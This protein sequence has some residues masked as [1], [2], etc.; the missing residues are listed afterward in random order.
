MAEETPP[1][2]V[3]PEKPATTEESVVSTTVVPEEPVVEEGS[4]LLKDLVILPPRQQKN[5]ATAVEQTVIRLP[6]IRAEE[7]VQSLRAA[8][9]ELVGFAAMTNYRLELESSAPT[10]TVSA[11]EQ[12]TPIVSPFTG[13]GAVVAVPVQVKSLE[14]D[15]SADTAVAAET[16][17]RTVTVLDDFGDLTALDPALLKDGSAFGIVLERYDASAVKDHVAR[18]RGLLDGSAPVVYSLMEQEAAP[19][20]VPAETAEDAVT[21]KEAAK[22]KAKKKLPALPIPN[23]PNGVKTDGSNLK[24]F[25]YMACG[26]DPELYHGSKRVTNGSEGGIKEPKKKKKGK[27]NKEEEKAAQEDDVKVPPEQLVREKLPRLNELEETLRIPCTI[28]Y[29]GFHPPPATR[30]CLGDIAYLEITPPDTT[31]PVVFV[32]A[33]GTGFYV[34]KSS[35]ARGRAV[36]DPSPAVEPCF[37]HTLLDCLLQKSPSIRDAWVAALAASKER[38]E[39]LSVVNDGPFTSLFRVAIRGDFGGFQS[40]ATAALAQLQLD[41]SLNTP[42]WLAPLPRQF[43]KADAWNRNAFHTYSSARVDDDLATSYGIDVRNGGVRDWN[44]E[45]QLAREMPTDTLQLRVERAR[46]IHRV[47]TEFGEASLLGVKAISEGHISSMNPNEPTRSQVYL[48]NNIFFSRAV[49]AGPETF[50]IAKGDKAARKSANRDVQCISIFHRMEKSGLYTLATVLIDYLGTRFVCQSILPGILIGEKSHTL[51]YGSVEAGL[52]LKWDEDFHKLL[53]DK[54]GEGM[55]VASRPVLRNPL[56]PER[57]EEI[58]QLKK[59]TLLPGM[60][61]PEEEEEEAV[62]PND[63]I[64][65]CIPL[66]AKGIR[67]SDQRKYVL[68]FGRLTPRDAN[69]VPED[70]GGSGKWETT[71]KQSKSSSAIPLSLHD[72]EWTMCVLRPELVTRYTQHGMAMYLQSKKEKKLEEEKAIKAAADVEGGDEDIKAEE[73]DK[74]TELTDEDLTFLKTLRLNINVFLPDVR[75]FE[76]INEAAAEQMKMDELRA[77]DA[78]VYLWDDVLPKITKAI[79]EG[80]VFQLPVD[81]KSLTEFIHRNGVNC[82]YLGRLATLAQEQEVSDAKVVADL[83]KGRLTVVERRMM[84]KSWLELLECEMVARAAKHVLDSYLTEHGLVAA[85][86]PAPTIASLLS[87][88]VSETDE[89]AS[90]TEARVAKRAPGQPDDDDFSGLTICDTGGDGDAVPAPIRSRYEIWQDIELEVGRRFRYSLTLYNTS[91]KSKRALYIPLLRRMCQRT[92]VRLFAKDYDVGGKCLCNGGDSFGGRL[93]VSYPISSLDIVDVVPLMKH[94]AAHGEGFVTCSLGPSIGLPP[95]HVSL[96]DARMALER[97]HVQTSGRALGPGLELAQEAASLYQRVTDNA[98]HPGV[99]ESMELT[100]NIFLE[101]GDPELAAANAAKQLG[102][103]VQSGGF[104]SA[105][106]F[107]AHMSLFQMHYT[108]KQMDQ[109]IKHLRAATYLLEIMSG[110]NHTEHFS[111][112]HKLGTVYSDAGYN[113]K[114]LSTSLKLFQEAAERDS[115]D[116]LMKGFTSRNLAKCHAGLAQFKE[117]SELEKQALRTFSLFAGKDH[118]ITKASEVDM[119]RYTKLAVAKGSKTL[120]SDSMREEEARAAGLAAELAADEEKEEKAKIKKKKKGKK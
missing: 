28:R 13:L 58:K 76:G 1:A 107:A 73:E 75:T 21:A 91:G 106:A 93:T 16:V 45:L 104:D 17:N 11:T 41:A 37:S 111:A 44:E 88:L 3:S 8:L 14:M 72:D 112:Y 5:K 113:G 26:E 119:Q 48:H 29:S 15:P 74:A 57:L 84:P 97:A 70:K 34:N 101:A 27:K 60:E 19:D 51:L 61:K 95:L 62:G 35:H 90:Q 23:G 18:L 115:C 6:P 25:F 33:V 94:A 81:G 77:A 108:A 31:M 43:M 87:A 49:D 78:A 24:D 53:S 66:E 30:R 54:V 12:N 4:A 102:L 86:Q 80:S 99:L 40:A 85:T 32:T 83:E 79:K 10:L 109:S 56:T 117:A 118:E 100:A 47:M 110:P 114:Y 68:D 55:M 7:P 103:A 120:E 38:A 96:P 59:A 2:V 67:G 116:R 50:K 64:E 9:S 89:S 42:S 20:I 36:F 105:A 92:G 22:I 98:A 82:R 65:S 69:W 46:L 39:I 63:V 71:K 52:P